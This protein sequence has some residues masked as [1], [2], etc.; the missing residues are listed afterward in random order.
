MNYAI[1][2]ASNQTAI[3]F[4]DS[5]VFPVNPSKPGTKYHCTPPMM[6]DMLLE[7]EQSSDTL[8]EI[9]HKHHI[10]Y[11]S[12]WELHDNYPEVKAAYIKA[13]QR[14]A[15][16]YTAEAQKATI[17]PASA[18]E[19]DKNG[20]T[21]MSM[22]AVRAQEFKANTMLRIA[23]IAELGT[24]ITRTQIDNRNVSININTNVSGEELMSAAGDLF[25]IPTE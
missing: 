15:W 5:T 6:R 2:P 9:C 3:D 17:I 10:T 4:F 7:Y 8:P 18:Y 25:A 21:R 20:C 22:A 24:H 1:L 16:I 12:F 11:R 13:R 23:E 19:I 14:K